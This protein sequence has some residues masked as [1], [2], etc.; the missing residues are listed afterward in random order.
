MGLVQNFRRSAKLF[1]SID[2]TAFASILVVLVFAVLIF[3]GMSYNP[4]HGNSVDLPKV[5]HPV[6]MRGALREDA[7]KVSILRDGKIYFG[8]DQIRLVD[9]PTK[10][11]DRLKN[12]EIEHKVYVVADMRA[13]WGTVKLAL[14]GVRTAGIIR[15]AFL[16]N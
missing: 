6:S 7:M 16:V 13:R 2:A 1:S 8:S 11:Q 12:R 9:L 3:H 5:S 4:H 14:D 15:V 10:I